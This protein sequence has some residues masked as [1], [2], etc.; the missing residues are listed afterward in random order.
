M[1]EGSDSEKMRKDL[2]RTMSSYLTRAE[3]IKVCC[4]GICYVFF[5]FL[6]G[7]SYCFQKTKTKTKQ[8]KK[9][10]SLPWP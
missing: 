10:G 9:L 2:S 5:F 8:K 3:K 6:C 1:H 7:D 4:N